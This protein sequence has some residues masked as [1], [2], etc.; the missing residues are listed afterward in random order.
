MVKVS[1]WDAPANMSD[2]HPHETLGEK[3]GGEGRAGGEQGRGREGGG[4]REGERTTCIAKHHSFIIK[5]Y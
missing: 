5:I 2:P 4:D 1:H 3:R